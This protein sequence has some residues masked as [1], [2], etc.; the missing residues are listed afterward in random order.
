MLS[1]GTAGGGGEVLIRLG[2]RRSGVS[3]LPSGL[4]ISP[5]VTLWHQRLSMIL[6]LLKGLKFII[7]YY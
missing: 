2:V 5:I 7:Q 6:L 1:A 3:V 4:E